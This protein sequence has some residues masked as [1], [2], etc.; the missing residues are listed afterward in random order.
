MNA[1][2]QIV[3]DGW[4]KTGCASYVDMICEKQLGVKQIRKLPG[5][6]FSYCYF[7]LTFFGVILIPSE[8]GTRIDP[9]HANISM[10]IMSV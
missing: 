3:Q 7:T 5:Q 10:A 9:K 8:T 4:Q 6:V 1:F 2:V